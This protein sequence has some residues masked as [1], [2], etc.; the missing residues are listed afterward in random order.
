MYRTGMF[1][2]A[3]KHQKALLA[4]EEQAENID[5]RSL[6]ELLYELANYEFK[7]GLIDDL[8]NTIA[9]VSNNNPPPIIKKDCAVLIAKAKT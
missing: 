5:S 9:E 2:K 3:A 7:A 1:E 6:T 8:L 4:K